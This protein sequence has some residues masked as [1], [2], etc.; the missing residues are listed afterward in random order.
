VNYPILFVGCPWRATADLVRGRRVSKRML[1]ADVSP[2]I[3]LLGCPPCLGVLVLGFWL[4]LPVSG[5]LVEDDHHARGCEDG[6]FRY[7][8][9]VTVQVTFVY[10]YCHTFYSCAPLHL[11]H[12][13]RSPWLAGPICAWFVFSQMLEIVHSWRMLYNR[14]MVGK[15]GLIALLCQASHFPVFDWLVI[16][17][18]YPTQSTTIPSVAIQVY[19][20]FHRG[21]S[22]V[23]FP[24]VIARASG[25]LA[26]DGNGCGQPL[27]VFIS[28]P[29]GCDGGSCERRNCSRLTHASSRPCLT[30]PFAA[31]WQCWWLWSNRSNSVHC[32]CEIAR[33][34]A[35]SGRVERFGRPLSGSLLLTARMSVWS[36][37][38]S[39]SGVH[40]IVLQPLSNV[41][42]KQTRWW[43]C[44]VCQVRQLN[45]E[46]HD[47]RLLFSVYISTYDTDGTM[48]HEKTSDAN[49][50]PGLP[51]CG[52]VK[53]FFFCWFWTW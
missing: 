9:A 32:R 46:R 27:Y 21:A 38:R 7:L 41:V 3:L 20:P 25:L 39:A 34:G 22:P 50:R 12:V 44:D 43:K 37:T 52:P 14:H 47:T 1:F 18:T 36:A 13:R 31:W 45:Q 51:E 23:F 4:D 26:L 15:L 11:C 42:K 17:L 29:R 33:S 2:P 28:P 16:T 8:A 10:Q 35:T 6:V 30:R 49:I 40:F 48:A 53:S 19:L 5:G 24:P